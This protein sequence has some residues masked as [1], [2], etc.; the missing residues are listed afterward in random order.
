MQSV[1]CRYM[2]HNTI[3]QL[4]LT[5]FF[6]NL[7]QLCLDILIN[8]WCNKAQHTQICKKCKI[9]SITQ[10]TSMQPHVWPHYFHF[11]KNTLR[12]K[13]FTIFKFLT[14]QF[15]LD[16]NC[17]AKLSAISIKKKIYNQRIEYLRNIFSHR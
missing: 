14:S 16:N 1:P 6:F 10:I 9:F 4:P 2:C 3:L 15:N 8:V 5:F 7:T 12:I 11:Y 13:Q 17:S